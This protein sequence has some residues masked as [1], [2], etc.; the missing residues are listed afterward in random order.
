MP[1]SRRVPT[2][3]ELIAAPK[4]FSAGS[5]FLLNGLPWRF[6]VLSD[7]GYDDLIKPVVNIARRYQIRCNEPLIMLAIGHVMHAVCVKA[8]STRSALR[9]DWRRRS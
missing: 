8:G 4:D 9:A 6:C 3:V 2:L 7:A 5:D 1:C